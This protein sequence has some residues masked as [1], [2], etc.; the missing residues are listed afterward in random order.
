MSMSNVQA[1]DDVA[2]AGNH[3]VQR[4]QR[5]RGS[6]LDPVDEEASIGVANQLDQRVQ[7]FTIAVQTADGLSCGCEPERKQNA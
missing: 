2:A 7:L 4:T 3:R 6:Q 1:H 5:N